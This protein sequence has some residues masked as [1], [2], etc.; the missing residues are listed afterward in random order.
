M[1]M[2]SPKSKNVHKALITPD[3]TRAALASRAQPK[4]LSSSAA[5]ACFL[6]VSWARLTPFYGIWAY[7]PCIV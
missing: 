6:Q 2:C 1:A 5:A 3:Q 4:I 7:R